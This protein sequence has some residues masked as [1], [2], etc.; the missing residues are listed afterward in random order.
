MTDTAA[1]PA[2]ASAHGSLAAGSSRL[3]QRRRAQTRLKAYGIAA[4][5]FALLALATLV[6]SVVTK[7]TGAFT[8]THFT[9]EVA[10]STE[11][12]GV[13]P[14]SPEEEIRRAPFGD[15][16]DETLEA[17]FPLASGRTERR[18]LD[19][20]VSGGAQFDLVEHV[21]ANPELLGQT[22]RFPL[23]AADLTD[24]YFQG[25]YGELI[26]RDVAGRLSVREGAD[27]ALVIDSSAE[28]F[29]EVL[30]TVKQS[31]Y[32]DADRLREQAAR[33]SNAVRVYGERAAAAETE[34]ARA[35]QLERQAAAEAE[36]D[37]LLAEAEAL[38]ARAE[39][40][41]GTEPLDEENISLLIQA[42]GGW[43]RMTEVSRSGGLGEA[44]TEVDLPIEET[45]DWRFHTTELAEARRSVSDHQIAWLETLAAEG[46]V[47]RGF[48]TRF[49]TAADSRA[50]ELAGIRGALVGSFWTMMV[51]FALAFPIGV[52]SAIYLEEFAPKN[53]FTNFIEVNINNL[54]AVPSIVYGLLGLAV[55]LNVFGVP[56]SAPL[57]GGLV[58]TLMT[59]PTIIIAAR[60]AIKAV[61]PSIREAALGVGA[62]KMQASFHHVLP[63]AMP[64]ILTG[65]I[66]GMAAALG[67]TA[68][69]IMIGMVAFIVETPGSITDSAT[70]LPV[71]IFRWYDFPEP[72]FEARAAA[73]ICVLL[74]FL[75]AMNALAIF[76][77]KRFERRW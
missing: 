53:R 58:L 76:L 9:Y 61:P 30:L 31:L 13:T 35:A 22:V 18:A 52:L 66:I 26:T 12:L 71:Q 59:L 23:I 11:A 25:G 24:Y 55:F 57:A 5:A 15:L 75:V 27:G 29:A 46:A 47:E 60:A 73:A 38:E 20:L 77:R 65:T 1:Q 48:N 39:T 43:I 14:E 6:G 21:V 40:E 64:G 67:E 44:L 72:G 45:G 70:V 33:Q 17:R 68:P 51:T 3:R 2:A 28:D 8:N 62:S 54:A 32:G 42:G 63:L 36:R 49:F 50:P 7:A 16:I 19:A 37:A 74:T 10:L 56:R 41:G 69:L 34:E 4:I